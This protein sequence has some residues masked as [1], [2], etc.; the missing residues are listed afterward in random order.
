M[1]PKN[2][3]LVSQCIPSYPLY[4]LV[5]L[6]TLLHYHYLPIVTCF[7][8]LHMCYS[9][10][11][12]DDSPLKMTNCS[13]FAGHLPWSTYFGKLLLGCHRVCIDYQLLF[14][15]M[16]PLQGLCKGISWNIPTTCGPK[17]YITYLYLGVL[18]FPLIN[19]PLMGVSP[20]IP[21]IQTP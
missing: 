20:D 9:Y 13:W 7:W 14:D 8:Y 21:I 1:E 12:F 5:T 15:I 4:A 11:Y 3:C 17:W 18:R 16:R 2:W 10:Q 19:I 6:V